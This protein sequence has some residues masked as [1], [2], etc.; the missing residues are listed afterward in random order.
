ML[1]SS[2][3]KNLPATHTKEHL[4]F[5]TPSGDKLNGAAA[6]VPAHMLMK[7]SVLQHSRQWG[8]KKN[9]QSYL[10]WTVLSRSKQT[11]TDLTMVLH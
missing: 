1:I 11:A 2:A 8:K 7:L 3:M 4:F 9:A 5:R 6:A 10:E